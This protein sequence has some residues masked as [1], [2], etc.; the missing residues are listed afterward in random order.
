MTEKQPDIKPESKGVAAR[1]RAAKAVCIFAAVFALGL[2]LRFTAP[3]RPDGLEAL[4]NFFAF[5]GFLGLAWWGS[6][7]FDLIAARR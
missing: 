2:L 1:R 6:V 7:L 3:G 5:V 4:A